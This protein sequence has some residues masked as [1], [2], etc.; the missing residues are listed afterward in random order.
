MIFS[1]H[2]HKN[3]LALHKTT[4]EFTKECNLGT[5]GDCIVGVKADFKVD[6]LKSFLR[7]KKIKIRI[8]I[9]NISDEITAIPNCS[10]CDDTEF[11]IR[12]SGFSS[13]R[14]FGI[15]ADKGA[16]NLKREIIQNLQI[17]DILAKVEVFGI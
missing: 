12:R 8:T 2:G 11:V 10:F 16:I 5:R 14:T 3:I 6:E 1:V 17:P 4:V 15:Y 9:D 7:Y 13:S